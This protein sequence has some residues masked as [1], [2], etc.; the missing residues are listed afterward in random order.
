MSKKIK[1]FLDF[2]GDVRDK[3]RIDYALRENVNIVVH[4]AALKQVTATE[5][6][7]FEAVKTNVLGTQKY[8]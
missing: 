5:Y 6:N 1:I 2:L 3:A 7:P 4:A 8:R